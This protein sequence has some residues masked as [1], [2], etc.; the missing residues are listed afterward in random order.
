MTTQP[1]SFDLSTLRASELR[2]AASNA[3]L[4]TDTSD[5][6][7]LVLLMQPAHDVAYPAE[8]ELAPVL[9]FYAAY[10][11]PGDQFIV[12]ANTHAAGDHFV[13]PIVGQVLREIN[14]DLDA[15][16][17]TARKGTL[18]QS[19]HRITLAG[20]PYR[21][22]V[23]FISVEGRLFVGLSLVQIVTPV[24]TLPD[25]ETGIATYPVETDRSLA[26]RIALRALYEVDT[27]Q[28]RIADALHQQT[29]L[30]PDLPNIARYTEF[31]VHGVMEYKD[32]CDEAIRGYAPS[33]PIEQMAVIDRNILRMAL[34]EFALTGRVP[35]RA[36]INEAVELAKIYGSEGSVAFINGVLGSISDDAPLL[37]R[38]KEA[39]ALQPIEGDAPH[40]P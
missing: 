17:R 32:I 8:D 16:V 30:V 11:Q 10:I 15:I 36:A 13:L 7:L 1:E 12:V 27:V 18:P 9:P 26:R 4:L 34:Y 22:R 39:Y 14:R 29:R 20:N 28:H 33:F 5:D 21:I 35:M 37:T 24:V 40:E 2:D 23:K 38:L 3:L 19:E 25:D 31:I 6:A